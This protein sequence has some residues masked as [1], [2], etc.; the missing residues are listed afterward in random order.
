MDYPGDY[1]MDRYK[2]VWLNIQLAARYSQYGWKLLGLIADEVSE[3]LLRVR[4]YPFM[5][6][7]QQQ[8]WVEYQIWTQLCKLS[9]MLFFCA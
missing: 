8:F 4:E 3:D 5:D 2:S 7:S 1:S 6:C 9:E